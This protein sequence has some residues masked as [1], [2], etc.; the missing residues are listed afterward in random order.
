MPGWLRKWLESVGES[1]AVA[2]RLMAL[3]AF[4]RLFATVCCDNSYLQITSAFAVSQRRQ[5]KS[6]QSWRLLEGGGYRR[7]YG[8]MPT[9]TLR[10]FGVIRG[11][12]QD[13]EV[14]ATADNGEIRQID[15]TPKHAVIAGMA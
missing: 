3:S 14:S 15:L 4:V 1:K 7:G 9:P 12:T 2:R 10:G 13:Q 5:K 6:R 11:P 8:D